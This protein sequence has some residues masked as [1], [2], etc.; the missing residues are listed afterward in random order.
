MDREYNIFFNFLS[1]HGDDLSFKIL[2]IPDEQMATEVQ[3]SE[4]SY[5]VIDGNL[6]DKLSVREIGK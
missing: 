5:P 2:P 6:H 1:G 3:Y 4:L